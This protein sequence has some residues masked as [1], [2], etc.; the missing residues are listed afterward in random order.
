MVRARVL[1]V[2]EH[3]EVLASLR[4]LL[5]F[6]ESSEVV[7][8]ATNGADAIEQARLLHPDLVL[9]DFVLNDMD[10]IEAASAIRSESPAT[11]IIILSVFEARDDA[12]RAR[13]AG[14]QCWIPKSFPP[15]ML[16]NELRDLAALHREGPS[17]FSK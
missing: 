3:E 16:L 15:E 12:M 6:E 17:G 2:D 10:G 8:A 1:I 11:D 5:E 14:V 9:M 13:L 4:R 7:G